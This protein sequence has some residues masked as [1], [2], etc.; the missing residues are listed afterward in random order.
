MPKH[1]GLDHCRRADIIDPGRVHQRRTAAISAASHR[2]GDAC[3][4]TTYTCTDTAHT[5][6]NPPGI[7]DS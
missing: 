4:D 6:T 7:D 3:T 2:A 1:R 5:R